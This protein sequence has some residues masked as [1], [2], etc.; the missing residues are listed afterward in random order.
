MTLYVND[1]GWIGLDT[2]LGAGVQMN[3]LE[4]KAV[5]QFLD[6][7]TAAAPSTQAQDSLQVPTAVQALVACP[8]L[9]EELAETL[10]H[11]VIGDRLL[12]H[13]RGRLFS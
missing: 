1:D 5:R 8:A 4:G 6:A 9:L 12:N 13:V 7:A 11:V 3:N 10:W 2:V